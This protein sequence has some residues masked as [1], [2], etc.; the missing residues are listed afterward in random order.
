M[1]IP[2]A[3]NVQLDKFLEQLIQTYPEDKDFSYYKRLIDNLK[4]FNVRKP[5]EYFASTI[6]KHTKQ[7]S[8]R[9]SD[10]FLNNFGQILNDEGA[11]K[12][13]QNEAF[14]LF[15]NIKKY[16]LEMSDDNKKVI[17]DYLNVLTKLSVQFLLS[18]SKK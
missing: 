18:Q 14:R 2:I 6:Q 15:N 11:D 17:W 16:W 4:K 3:F 7:I 9:N 12:D 13:T 10:F 8:E 1:S 5:I